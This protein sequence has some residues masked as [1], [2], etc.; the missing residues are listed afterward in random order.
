MYKI[1]EVKTKKELK[2][3][4]KFPFTL[5]KGNQ[6]WVPPLIMDELNVFNPKKNPAFEHCEIRYWM[7]FENESPVGRIAGIIHEEEA[8][9]E[10]M[11]RFGWIDFIDDIGVVQMLLNAVADWG[12]ERGLMDMHGPMGFTDMDYE[13]MLVEGFDTPGTIATIYNYPYYPKLLEELGFEKSIDWV[14]LKGKVPKEAPRRVIRRAEIVENRFEFKSLKLK[15]KKE[16]QAYGKELFDVLNEAYAE[17]YGFHR[18]TEKQIDFYIS[19]YLGFVVVDLLSL[20]VDKDG[21]LVGFAITM[22]SL[23]KAFQK[24]QGRLLPTGFLHILQALKKSD[25]ADMYLIGVLPEY[26]KYGVTAIIF[27][28]LIQAYIKRGV[29][30]ALT[31]QMLES[32]QN[33]L[34]QFNEFQES[35]EI[36]KRRRCYKK[37]LH[38]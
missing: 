11:I 17:L 26:Q 19:Q 22:P 30:Y 6:N 25:L 9:E 2:A 35:S 3:F 29:K 4:V 36:Y 24:A 20:I 13:G 34:T 7:V 21:K 15:S 38:G 33:V 23:T 10:K 12:K 37:A 28:D 31:N 27:R 14:E 18:L 8:R 16:A 1:R 32:N 5:Y